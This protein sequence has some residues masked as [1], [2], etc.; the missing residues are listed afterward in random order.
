MTWL[1][2]FLMDSS[3]HLFNKYAFIACLLCISDVNIQSLGCIRALSLRVGGTQRQGIATQV[4]L[5]CAW[6]LFICLL[7]IYSLIHPMCTAVTY[8]AGVLYKYGTSVIR[9]FIY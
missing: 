4:Y 3:L 7:F 6:S 5:L 8:P 2:A 1:I 9:S